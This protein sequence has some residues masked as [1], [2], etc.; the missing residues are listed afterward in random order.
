MI[1]L[2][3]WTTPNGHKITIFLEETKL[4]YT[5]KTVNITKG[6]QFYPEFL[7]ISPNNRIPAIVDHDPKDGGG[8]LAV[9]ES[10]AILQYLAEK[11][12]QLIPADPR[13][14]SD[15]MQWLFWQMSGLGPMLGQNHHFSRYAPEPIPYAIERY[16]KET[17]RLYSILDHRLQQREFI[18]GTYSV[19]D[20]A[21]YPW[22][23]PHARQGI[24]LEE[25]PDLKRWFDT[26][27]AR[28][29]VKRSY[30]LATRINTAPTVTNA[31]RSVLFGQGRR[32]A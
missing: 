26:V 28:P 17:E 32:A 10:G 21:S 3:Y 11:T 22:I 13:G 31:A 6:E 4:P 20:I 29:A 27:G 1:D 9:F 15:V 8:P 18:A 7:K 16:R 2:Y 12:G 5:I 30:E 19:A 24:K 23:V 14:R 25:F